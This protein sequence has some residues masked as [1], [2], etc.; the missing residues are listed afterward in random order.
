MPAPVP[1]LS[2][3]AL[4]EI[5]FGRILSGDISRNAVKPESFID[6]YPKGVASLKRS[7]NGISPDKVVESI[8]LPAYQAAVHGADKVRRLKVDWPAMLHQAAVNHALGV[9]ME[10]A[11]NKLKNGEPVDF[12]PIAKALRRHDDGLPQLTQLSQVRPNRSD[13]EL[14]G[15]EPLDKYVGG[16]PLSSLTLVIGPPGVG[17]SYYFLKVAQGYARRKKKVVL[18]SLE[19]TM[20]QVARRCM[21]LMGMTRKEMD[22]IYICDDILSPTDITSI[23]ARTEDAELIGVDFAE[24]MVVGERSE[25]TM[26]EA[27]WNLAMCAKSLGHPVLALGQQNRASLADMLPSL[28]AARNTGMTDILA[29]LE[30]GL[31]ARSNVLRR[32]EMGNAAQPIPLAPGNGA[33]IVIKARYGTK[34]KEPVGVIEVPFNG[35][36]G[37]GDKGVRWHSLAT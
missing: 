11:S 26:G 34:M 3:T 10:R 36:K 14:T 7:K 5:T 18:F 24:L 22:Y 37:W 33:Q 17:K 8:G 25:Q 16:L 32:V 20:Q 4:S 13:Y 1:V 2:W 9:V 29:A 6:P 30:I 23:S 28:G 35:E 21:R 27:Y 12:A 19:M 31:Y 15:Y